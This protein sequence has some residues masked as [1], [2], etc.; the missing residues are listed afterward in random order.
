[1]SIY[2][3]MYIEHRFCIFFLKE[4]QLNLLSSCFLPFGTN[5]DTLKPKPEIKSFLLLEVNWQVL[6]RKIHNY[7]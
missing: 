4:E 1:M 7:Y 3:R 2:D 6:K 5:T